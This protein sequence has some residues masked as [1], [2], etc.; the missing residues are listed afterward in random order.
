MLKSLLVMIAV[1][2]SVASAAEQSTMTRAESYN[3]SMTNTLKDL[4]YT[5]FIPL[6]TTQRSM[7]FGKL[8]YMTPEQSFLIR[9]DGAEKFCQ[10]ID[11]SLK[12]EKVKSSAMV[13]GQGPVIVKLV[14]GIPQFEILD[15]IEGVFVV[16]SILCTSKEKLY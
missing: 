10:S 6:L 16:D 7:L 9:A 1:V 3:V 14:A 4:G 2:V 11:E 5:T 15:S 13:S 8:V 12:T